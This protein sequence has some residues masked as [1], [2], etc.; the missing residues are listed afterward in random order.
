MLEKDIGWFQKELHLLGSPGIKPLTLKP[1]LWRPLSGE[2]FLDLIDELHQLVLGHH[3]HMLTAAVSMLLA[4]Q[5][6]VRL[7]L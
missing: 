4:V 5:A 3:F 2:L 1:L 6:R 7:A